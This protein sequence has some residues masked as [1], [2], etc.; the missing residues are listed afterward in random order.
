MK[1]PV[2]FT[3][4]VVEV[5]P[6]FTTPEIS[7]LNLFQTSIVIIDITNDKAGSS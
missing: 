3:E 1:L 2:I 6:G 4:P 7:G 5:P